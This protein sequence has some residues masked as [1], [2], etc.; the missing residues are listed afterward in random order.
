MKPSIPDCG[1][2]DLVTVPSFTAVEN[3]PPLCNFF[4]LLQKGVS[5]DKETM[6]IE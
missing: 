1:K 4:S 6:A 2:N 3:E 5:G